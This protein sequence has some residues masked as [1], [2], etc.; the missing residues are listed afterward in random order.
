MT[1]Y[2]SFDFE[3][4]F[5]WKEKRED[6]TRYGYG[7]VDA[8][9]GI[10]LLTG[11]KFL[12]NGP[13]SIE[14]C[15]KE[16][17]NAKFLNLLGL[18]IDTESL[19]IAFGYFPS[20][21]SYVCLFGD[22][23]SSFFERYIFYNG[24]DKIENDKIDTS[25][26]DYKYIIETMKLEN[27]TDARDAI[28]E[29]L[30]EFFTETDYVVGSEHSSIVMNLVSLYESR[31]DSIRAVSEKSFL[32][33]D[34]FDDRFYKLSLSLYKAGMA[35]NSLAKFFMWPFIAEDDYIF[36]RENRIKSSSNILKDSLLSREASLERNYEI[37]ISL[38]IPFEFIKAC[39]SYGL[40][41]KNRESLYRTGIRDYT[42]HST[43]DIL[44]K[45]SSKLSSMSY[46]VDQSAF[47]YKGDSVLS[48]CF[49]IIDLIR[50]AG[51]LDY[52]LYSVDMILRYKNRTLYDSIMDK[53]KVREILDESLVSEVD[54]VKALNKY[55]EFYELCYSGSMYKM[56]VKNKFNF[57]SFTSRQLDNIGP[58]LDSS[59]RLVLKKFP[60]DG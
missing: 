34:V 21:N 10:E 16:C 51:W 36:V 60:K 20:G 8:R 9:S 45:L 5:S 18:F 11:K 29:Y 50:A 2:V 55:L 26:L 49:N 19:D 1:R 53:M 40:G 12:K 4:I 22:T 6:L 33:K 13:N 28:F 17:N 39:V 7:S 38:G 56:Q 41:I 3:N 58:V 15:I 57:A 48:L 44:G 23:F 24:T 37:Y 27:L 32:N 42:S 54:F 47:G 25:K 30:K 52:L 35:L 31:S 43:W 46:V 59:M 14:L